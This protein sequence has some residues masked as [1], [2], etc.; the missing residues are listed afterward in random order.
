MDPHVPYLSGDETHYLYGTPASNV[1]A[2]RQYDLELSYMDGHLQRLFDYAQQELEGE[3]VFLVASD[4]GEEFGE[5]GERGHG[6]SLFSELIG[7]PVMIHGV[8][9]SM[10][11]PTRSSRDVISSS[12][13]PGCQNVGASIWQPGQKA[14]VGTLATQRSRLRRTRARHP[15]CMACCAPTETGSSCA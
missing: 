1:E 9:D 14:G 10:A 8:G 6:H 7:V 5:H 4:H 15:S 3:T 2:R 12:S 13:W 11:R